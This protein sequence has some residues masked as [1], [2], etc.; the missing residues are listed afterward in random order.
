MASSTRARLRL[1]ADHFLT[2]DPSLL[3]PSAFTELMPRSAWSLFSCMGESS[4]YVVL[5][6]L[7]GETIGWFRCSCIYGTLFGQGTWVA[8]KHRREGLASQMWRHAMKKL[9]PKRVQVSVISRSG[10]AFARSLQSQHQKLVFEV[11]R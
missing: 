10:R 11:I 8:A 5:A 4:E 3:S 1:V 2:Y 9:K 7:Y 6:T